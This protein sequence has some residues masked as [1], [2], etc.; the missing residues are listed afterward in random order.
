MCKFLLSTNHFQMLICEYARKNLHKTNY[1][2]LWKSLQKINPSKKSTFLT[3]QPLQA[4]KFTCNVALLRLYI[5]Q[6]KN[7]TS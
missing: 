1:V 6:W 2:K 5:M 7:L 3:E 4:S